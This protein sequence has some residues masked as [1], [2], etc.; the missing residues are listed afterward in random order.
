M[1]LIKRMYIGAATVL[2][3]SAFSLLL[4]TVNVVLVA[5]LLEP[6]SFGY[7]STLLALCGI[8]LIP[9]DFGGETTT[10]KLISEQRFSVGK[11]ISTSFCIKILISSICIILYL[12]ILMGTREH[13]D[14]SQSLFNLY[15]FIAPFLLITESFFRSGIGIF[16]GLKRAD[17]MALSEVSW[18]AFQLIFCIGLILVGF[19]VFGAAAGYGL[20]SLTVFLGGVF[21]YPKKPIGKPEKK[22]RFRQ[23][24]M[25]NPRVFFLRMKKKLISLK[26]SI[27]RS[28]PPF[29]T[30]NQRKSELFT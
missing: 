16:Q 8:L 4:A 24:S 3:G 5:R 26:N 11:I 21:Y 9:T 1:G 27:D 29:F 28:S 10:A 18:R 19:G 13:W 25:V 22:P 2:M 6:T 15:L 23:E 30:E 17:L 7:L 20:A 14:L 12:L